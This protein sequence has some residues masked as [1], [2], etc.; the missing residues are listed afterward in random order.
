MFLIV[1]VRLVFFFVFCVK[2]NLLLFSCDVCECMMRFF[3][4]NSYIRFLASV[5][6]TSRFVNAR[7]KSLVV[8]I[9]VC[10]VLKNNMCC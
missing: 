8:L 3:E 10:L 6:A 4:L 5:F 2:G 7:T 1:D 9:F